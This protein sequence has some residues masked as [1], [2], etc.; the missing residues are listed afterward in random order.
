MASGLCP[1]GCAPSG[2]LPSS[3]TAKV[4]NKFCCLLGHLFGAALISI[5]YAKTIFFFLFLS[6]LFC[7]YCVN[8]H[9]QHVKTHGWPQYHPLQGPKAIQDDAEMGPGRL[10]SWE[11]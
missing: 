5:C 3:S 9:P 1:L 6:L 2:R 11:S 7:C 8:R 4:K 10:L